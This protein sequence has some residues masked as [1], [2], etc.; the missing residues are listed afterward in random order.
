MCCRVNAGRQATDHGQPR[1]GQCP[2]K[3]GG[4]PLALRCGL[5]AAHHG[6]HRLLQQFSPTVQVQQRRRVGQLGQR[7]RIVGVGQCQQVAPFATGQP[8][9]HGRLFAPGIGLHDGLGQPGR[10][11]AGQPGRTGLQHRFGR[12]ERMQQAVEADR[13][14][15][16]NVG[17]MQ[18][19]RRQGSGRTGACTESVRAGS[20]RYNGG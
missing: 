1:S 15:A 10:H 18:Q 17:Q 12:A 16:R 3:A 9:L 14:Q 13:T 4:I 7:R 11:D 8:C 6:Q 5:P 20:C 19:G 2:G